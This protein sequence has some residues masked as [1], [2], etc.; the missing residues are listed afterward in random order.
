M[1][2]GEGLGR[3]PCSSPAAQGAPSGR[4][5]LLPLPRRCAQVVSPPRRAWALRLAA[6]PRASVLLLMLPLPRLLLLLLSLLIVMMRFRLLL[7]PLLPWG[8]N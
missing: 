2:G 3:G 8:Q 5:P 4:R 7:H 1:L 6:R